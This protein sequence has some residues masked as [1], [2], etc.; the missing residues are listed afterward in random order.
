MD[1]DYRLRCICDSRAAV[2]GITTITDLIMPNLYQLL[3]RVSLLICPNHRDNR[4][5]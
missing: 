4:W 5:Y 3:I 1:A 2:E